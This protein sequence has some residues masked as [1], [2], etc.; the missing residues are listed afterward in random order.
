MNRVSPI[1]RIAAFQNVFI[2]QEE[3]QSWRHCNCCLY[4]PEE[5]PLYPLVTELAGGDSAVPSCN[6]TGRG[7]FRCALL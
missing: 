7:R 1:E 2:H 3:H 6:G 4:R 5:I